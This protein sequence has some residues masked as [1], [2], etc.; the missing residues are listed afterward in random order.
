MFN[1]YLKSY[2]VTIFII[3]FLSLCVFIYYLS[4]IQN[5]TDSDVSEP[6]SQNLIDTN[7]Y[8]NNNSYFWPLPGYHRITSSFGPRKSPTS[9]SSSNHSGVDIAAPEGTTIYSMITGQ[10]IFIGF[11]GAGGCT[12]TVSAGNMTVSYCHVSPNYIVSIGQIVNIGEA[13]G[14]VGPKI[15]YGIPNNPYKDSNRESN[16]WCYNW[17]TSSSYDKRKWNSS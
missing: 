6:I 10:V 1:N 2:F 5:S 16:Q 14:S 13:V 12:I 8:F 4:S 11:K 7:Y 17:F 9:G 3:I 15:L